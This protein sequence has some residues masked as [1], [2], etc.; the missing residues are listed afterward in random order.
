MFSAHLLGEI[1][2]ALSINGLSPFTADLPVQFGAGRVTVESDFPFGSSASITL[3]PSEAKAFRLEF[4]VPARSVSVE[5]LLVNG[6]EV[7][8]VKNGRGF[9][10]INRTW[11]EDD[12]IEIRYTCHPAAHIQKGEERKEWVAFTHGP[13]VLAQKISEETPLI[14]FD[15][16][17][18][19]A[20]MLSLIES[21]GQT[22]RYRIEGTDIELVP[23]YQA[24]TDTTGTRTYFPV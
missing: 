20:S 9:Y 18:P 8:P 22:V 17:K 19:S 21:D 14:G 13:L 10:E 12:V 15:G 11:E 16:D 2:G 24:G 3:H 6:N 4:R 7:E 1:D 5:K 23:Y